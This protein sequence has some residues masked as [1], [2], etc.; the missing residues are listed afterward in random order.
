[1]SIRVKNSM[2]KQ[3]IASIVATVTI[4]IV[5]VSLLVGNNMKKMIDN[6]V[7]EDSKN[8]LYEMS[9]NVNLILETADKDDITDK[10]QDYCN[11][12]SGQDNLEYAVIVDTN[13]KAIAHSDSVKLNKV[14]DDEF[15]VNAVHQGNNGKIVYEKYWA[16]QQNCWVYNM[17]S[18]IYKDGKQFGVL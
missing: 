7:L 17:L 1:M 2:K 5:A 4:L 6:S 18:P 13:V 16:D 12:K 14:Y 11:E 9:S 15:T 10:L 3:I 8:M